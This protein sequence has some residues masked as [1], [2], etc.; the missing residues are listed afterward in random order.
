L[1]HADHRRVA[2]QHR[3]QIAARGGGVLQPYA[4]AGEQERLVELLATDRLG[5]HVLRVRDHGGL[6]CLAALGDRDGTRDHREREHDSDSGQEDPEAAV[7]TSLA[8]AFALRLGA[9][10]GDE[11]ALERG[12]RLVTRR[13]ANRL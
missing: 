10:G 5:T 12:S 6:A 8:L 4:G 3:E 9:A 1:R 13:Q 2:R 7:R 11:S